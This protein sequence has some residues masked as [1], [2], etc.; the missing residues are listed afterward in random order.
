MHELLLPYEDTTLVTWGSGPLNL[1]V[2]ALARVGC[3]LPEPITHSVKRASTMVY[4]CRIDSLTSP[5]LCE[6]AVVNQAWEKVPVKPKKARAGAGARAGADARALAGRA[7]TAS[8]K[9]NMS[10]QL[11]TGWLA[12][13]RCY[14]EALDREGDQYWPGDSP[15]CEDVAGGAAAE[16]R[17]GQQQKKQKQ[18]VAHANDASAGAPRSWEAEKEAEAGLPAADSGDTNAGGAVEHGT[19]ERKGAVARADGDDGNGGGPAEDGR[20]NGRKMRAQ[21]AIRSVEDICGGPQTVALHAGWRPRAGPRGGGGAVRPLRKARCV[22]RTIRHSGAPRQRR[23]SS[24]GAAQLA[25][26]AVRRGAAAA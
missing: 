6:H 15:F 14:L 26:G 22:F 16:G 9:P 4:F 19:K 1:L 7:P 11:C 25:V 3:L 21:P 17:Q 23:F 24:A 18:A 13:S 10:L 20:G 2:A 8:M 5:C 12:A